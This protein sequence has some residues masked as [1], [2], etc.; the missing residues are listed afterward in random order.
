M[1]VRPGFLLGLFVVFAFFC[2]LIGSGVPTKNEKK[3]A[4]IIE[5]MSEE[6]IMAQLLNEHATKLG[7][8]TNL[9]NEFILRSLHDTNGLGFSFENRTNLSGQLIDLWQ[10][11]FRFTLAGRTNFI[12][13]SAGPNQ[14]FGDKDDIIFNSAS[15]S[16]QKP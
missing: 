13:R 10:T 5:T 9:G 2:W 3:Q 6:R 4:M 12:V 11:P 15:N 16:F 8:M 1:R 14:K 7:G